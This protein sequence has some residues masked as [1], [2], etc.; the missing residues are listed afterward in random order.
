MIATY[1]LVAHG[2]TIKFLP[3]SPALVEGLP[4]R[5]GRP[6]DINGRGISVRLGAIDA[7]ETHFGETHQELAG[8]NA[9]PRRAAAPTGLQQRPLLPRPAQ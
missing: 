6:P 8:A 3:D 1:A 2:D 4:R 5:S 9:A 7:L